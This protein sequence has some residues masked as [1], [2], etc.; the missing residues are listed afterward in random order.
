MN[1]R[2]LIIGLLAAALLPGSAM[3]QSYAEQIVQQLR[4][5][6]YSGITVSNTWL[7]RT[8]I[9]ARSG[10]GSRE[11]IID[12]RTG[13]ILRDL[14]EGGRGG[15]RIIDDRSGSGSGRDDDDDDRDDDRDDDEEEEE[16]EEKEEKD[17]SGS[18]GG[19][20]DND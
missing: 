2:H 14:S 17:N 6:G 4:Q 5:Q 10:N 19:G 8:R 20:E 7:G 15:Q 12:P 3:A 16:E 1:R 9:V 13:E 18:G 11:I